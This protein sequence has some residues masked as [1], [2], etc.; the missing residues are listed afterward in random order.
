[1][2]VIASY[3]FS[4]CGIVI[5]DVLIS[6]RN[7]ERK[8]SKSIT[9]PSLVEDPSDSRNEEYKVVGVDRKV[10]IVSDYCAIAWAG[11]KLYAHD[12]IEKI[13]KLP[14]SDAITLNA[15]EEIFE[16]SEESEQYK[17]HLSIVGALYDT[18][19][20]KL[21]T[22]GFG[23]S[24]HD[25][26]FFGSVFSA[27]SGQEVIKEYTNIIDKQ[28]LPS[29]QDDEIAQNATGYT[30][31]HIAHLL[32]TEFRQGSNA[33]SIKDSFGGG[34]EAAIFY[35]G[36]FHKIKADYMFYDLHYINNLIEISLPRAIIS[37]DYSNGR[38]IFNS[39]STDGKNNDVLAHKIVEINTFLGTEEI[40]N[41]D[42]DI[43][44][45]CCTFVDMSGHL[46]QP[47]LTTFICRSIS[48]DVEWDIKHNQLEINYSK[49]FNDNICRF[50]KSIY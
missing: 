14:N 41:S 4:N 5:G 34:Y 6:A 9:L 16:R 29:F 11:S 21:S 37:Q 1:M 31:K 46:D 36:K 45:T 2:T 19:T 3:N 25:S 27:G 50:I 48:S 30:L 28:E 13:I 23:A 26:K 35:D 32:G 12:F 42:S 39:I 47:S 22:F 24:H 10:Y 43:F 33:E 7:R 18:D 17:L 8:S 44:L 40:H 20:D 38:L 15:I 49:K